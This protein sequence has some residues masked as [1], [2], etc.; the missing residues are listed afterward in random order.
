MWMDRKL[1]LIMLTLAAID[2]G[3]PTACVRAKSSTQPP[4]TNVA[5]ASGATGTRPRPQKEGGVSDTYGTIVGAIVAG[6]FVIIGSVLTMIASLVTTWF[7]ERSRW[8]REQKSVLGVVG[9]EAEAFKDKA[10]RYAKG[11][12]SADE[13]RA[14]QPLLVAIASAL[15]HMPPDEAAAYRKIVVLFAELRHS[16]DKKRAEAV[17]QACDGLLNMLKKGGKR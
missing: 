13:M 6:V 17:I 15:G 7:A 9:A 10:D 8:N 5:G 2:I 1:L 12:C 3:W 16:K 14:S 11:Q 4:D